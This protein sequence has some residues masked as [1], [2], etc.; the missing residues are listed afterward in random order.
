MEK[1][2]PTYHKPNIRVSFDFYIELDQEDV[3]AKMRARVQ[4][5]RAIA[6]QWVG[7]KTFE[8][9]VTDLCG[10]SDDERTETL[11]RAAY[12]MGMSED[13]PFSMERVL[14]EAGTTGEKE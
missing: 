9:T 10:P 7:T 11:C 1:Q 14:A 5:L 4:E 8:A 6:E 13:I 2:L 12:D 3:S